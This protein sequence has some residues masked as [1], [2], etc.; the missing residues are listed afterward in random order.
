MCCRNPLQGIH[1]TPVTASHMMH[2]TDFC[3]TLRY[4]W[5]ILDLWEASQLQSGCLIVTKQAWLLFF[6]PASSSLPP[7]LNNGWMS[8]VEAMLR[9][10]VTNRIFLR[11]FCDCWIQESLRLPLY[12]SLSRLKLFSHLLS[13]HPQAATEVFLLPWE[14]CACGCTAVLPPTSHSLKAD[15]GPTTISM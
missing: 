10:S 14:S 4:V 6:S 12:A 13:W 11:L 5:G 9:F 1:S 15:T 7:P 8:P 2:V 3:I